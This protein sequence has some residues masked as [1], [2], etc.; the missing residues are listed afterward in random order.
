LTQEPGA[1]KSRPGQK[2]TR[3]R[4]KAPAGTPGVSDPD[5]STQQL[6]T[7]RPGREIEP[8]RAPLQQ[9]TPCAASLINPAKSRI[10]GASV[11]A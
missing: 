11:K 4:P 3:T 2:R 1:A 7:F 8:L 10:I 5:F 6:K 9:P